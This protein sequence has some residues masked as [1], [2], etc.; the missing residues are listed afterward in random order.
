MEGFLPYNFRGLFWGE[1][2]WNFT[3]IPKFKLNS[4]LMMSLGTGAL[5]VSGG[6]KCNKQRGGIHGNPGSG[7]HPKSSH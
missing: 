1:Y 3:A 4:S 2:F 6:P 7:N 5:K